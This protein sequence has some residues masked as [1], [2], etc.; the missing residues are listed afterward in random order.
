MSQLPLVEPEFLMSYDGTVTDYR[1]AVDQTGQF[2]VF[3]RALAGSDDYNLYLLNLNAPQDGPQRFV[4]GVQGSTRPDWSWAWGVVAFD[5]GQGIWMSQ[6]PTGST[7]LLNGTAGMIYPAWYPTG[8]YLL[9]MNQQNSADPN[10]CTSKILDDGS[11]VQK[12]MANASLWGGMPAVNPANACQFVFA[13]QLMAGQ[14]SYQ[15]DFNYIWFVDS[16]TTPT[17]IRPLDKSVPSGPFDPAFQGR[18][19]WWSPDGKWIAFE[20]NRI[21]QGTN[22]YAIYI[23][24]SAGE[25]AAMQ[26]TDTKWNGNHAKW[27]PNGTELFATFLQ[28]PGL[29]PPVSPLR[30]IARVDVSAFLNAAAG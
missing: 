28:N 7:S 27:F 16:S 13:G 18:A 23:Q 29:D 26:V 17:T 21:D 30:G 14:T 3:E 6:G 9:V 19:P 5:N 15:Q 12:V 2:I 8:N 22:S 24:D 1:S 10:P 11:I 25:A 4:P 20:S